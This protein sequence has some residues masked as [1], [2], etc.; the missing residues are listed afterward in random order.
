MFYKVGDSPIELSVYETECCEV[1]RAGHG[2][3]HRTGTVRHEMHTNGGS[4]DGV[5]GAAQGRR[6]QDGEGVRRGAG[7]SR[8]DLLALRGNPDKIPLAAAWS[9]ADF[10][11]CTIDEVV[12]HEAAGIAGGEW[13]VFYDSLSPEGRELMDDLRQLVSMRE[14]RTARRAEVS[15]E[16]RYDVMLRHYERIFYAQSDE[17]DGFGD[18][19]FAPRAEARAR[20]RPSWRSAPARRAT[21]ARA[22]TG[23]RP[24]PAGTG[25]P[26]SRTATTRR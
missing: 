3:P 12:G 24:A 4:P 16:A 13:Q 6:V 20:S 7:R 15:R 23:R 22:G 18:A 26:T 19:A 9:I 14:R 2:A 8:D 25:R 5:D 21:A 10:L 1:L 17:E 11:G